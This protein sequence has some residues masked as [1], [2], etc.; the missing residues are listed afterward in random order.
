MC[1]PHNAFYIHNALFVDAVNKDT[2]GGLLNFIA[3]CT[4]LS[5][6]HY[7]VHVLYG[8]MEQQN[9]VKDLGKVTYYIY[10][11]WALLKYSQPQ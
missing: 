10:N 11:N 7:D 1:F 6:E 2:I 9:R 5:T 3:H 4:R 8:L